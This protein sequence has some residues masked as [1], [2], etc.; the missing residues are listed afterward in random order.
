[1]RTHELPK[2]LAP[3]RSEAQTIRGYGPGWIAVETEKITHSVILGSDGLRLD[4][5]C[6]RFE[7]LGPAHF[8]TLAAHLAA[9]SAAQAAGRPVEVLLLGSGSR[10]RFVPAAWLQPLVAMGLS[11]ETMDTAAACRTY[12]VLAHEGRRVVAALVLEAPV[13]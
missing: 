6:A 11:L 1:M 9:A 10:H 5:D 13:A 4:W 2:K 8:A 12:N 7:D 3:E